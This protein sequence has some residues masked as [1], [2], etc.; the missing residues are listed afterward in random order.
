MSKLV[1][2]TENG[3]TGHFRQFIHLRHL[4]LE[5]EIFLSILE[6]FHK[7]SFS[8]SFKKGCAIKKFDFKAIFNRLTIQN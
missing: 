7:K 5:M 2:E 8:L 4:T 1:S 3:V 6:V